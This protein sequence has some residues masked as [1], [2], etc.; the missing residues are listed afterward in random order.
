MAIFDQL[1]LLFSGLGGIHGLLLAAYLFFRQPGTWSNR[2]LA[3]VI[4]MMSIR[5]L[6]SVLFYFN[7]AI[8]KQILQLGL[9]ACFLIGPLL[10][11]Y[12][13]QFLG[14]FRQSRFIGCI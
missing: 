6:K 2:F 14:T 13:L 5:V 9:S 7:P 8:G 3:A 4:L 1:L 12:C 11:C 10:Y